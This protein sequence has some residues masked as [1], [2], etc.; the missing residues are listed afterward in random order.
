MLVRIA[1]EFLC[2]P[3]ISLQRS[4]AFRLGMDA[5]H[6]AKDDSA[7]WWVGKGGTRIGLN[8]VSQFL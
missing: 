5:W 8:L 3:C 1:D 4:I 6:P 7:E 2:N